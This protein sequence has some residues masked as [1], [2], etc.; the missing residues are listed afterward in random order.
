MPEAAQTPPEAQQ[1]FL[2]PYGAYNFRLEIQG[3]ESARFTECLGLGIK[4]QSIQYR[5]GG[6]SQVVHHLPGPVRY[7]EVELRYGLTSSPQLW[8]WFT[9]ACAGNVLRKNV[10]VVVL[11]PDGVQEAM[12]WNLESAWPCEWRGAALDALGQEVAI[13]TLKLVYESL[14]RA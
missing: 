2:E 4:I 6:I 11:R 3:I 13:E 7:G 8:E 10:S 1:G 14:E 5:E 9:A 12:R